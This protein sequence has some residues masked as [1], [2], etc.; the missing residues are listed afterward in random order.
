M[1]DARVVVDDAKTW[2]CAVWVK[3]VDQLLGEPIKFLNTGISQISGKSERRES[4]RSRDDLG[5]FGNIR[6]FSIY[7][8]NDRQIFGNIEVNWRLRWDRRVRPCEFYEFR[9]CS[10]PALQ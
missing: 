9:G 8:E 10:R 1:L 6:R 5:D 2:F 3:K 7:F 4:S